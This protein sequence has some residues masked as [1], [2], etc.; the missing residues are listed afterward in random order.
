M[1]DIQRVR[2]GDKEL[3]SISGDLTV[4]HANAL[5]T[6]LLEAMKNA[7]AIVLAV[8]QV[9]GLDVSFPQLVCS[10]HRTAAALGRELTI[11][12]LEQD[13]LAELLLQAG[14]MRHTGCAENTRKTCLWLRCEGMN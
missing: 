8:G 5:K 12:G 9:T 6:V 3:V 11:T 14:F 7:E 10:A 4:P 2:S 13:R 1:A